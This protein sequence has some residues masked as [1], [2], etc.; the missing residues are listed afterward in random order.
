MTVNIITTGK[1]FNDH[2]GAFTALKH[3]E[4]TRKLRKVPEA[5]KYGIT[6]ACR[7][8]GEFVLK[9]AQPVS[10]EIKRKLEEA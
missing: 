7:I 5:G 1:Y 8:D 10:D 4:T 9:S 6:T 3:R 2:P